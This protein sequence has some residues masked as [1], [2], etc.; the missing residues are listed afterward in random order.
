[1]QIDGPSGW[2]VTGPGQTA[3]DA[4]SIRYSGALDATHQWRSVEDDKHGLS[5][6]WAG[7]K[8]FWSEPLF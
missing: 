4:T 2:P 8:R 3:P 6:I 1:V 5:A 7:L